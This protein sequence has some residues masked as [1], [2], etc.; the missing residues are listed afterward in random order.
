MMRVLNWC[1]RAPIAWPSSPTAAFHL[2]VQTV[3]K[4]RIALFVLPVDTADLSATPTAGI[5]ALRTA[6]AGIRDGLL[7]RRSWPGILV[8]S[9]ACVSGHLATFAIAAA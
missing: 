5:R 7:T 3:A 1:T 2:Y 4:T 9:A 8:A 6:K